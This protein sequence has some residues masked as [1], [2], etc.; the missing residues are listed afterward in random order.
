MP[1]LR[2]QTNITEPPKFGRI[3]IRDA[4]NG[5][6]RWAE[7]IILERA[8]AEGYRNAQNPEDPHVFEFIVEHLEGKYSHPIGEIITKLLRFTKSEDS[9]DLAKAVAWITLIHRHH[10]YKAGG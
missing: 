3:S 9:E 10:I 8:P 5:L 2:K 6:S 7:Q 4:T 1:K